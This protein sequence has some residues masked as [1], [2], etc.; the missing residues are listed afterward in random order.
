SLMVVDEDS[1]Q[2]RLNAASSAHLLEGRDDGPV[3]LDQTIE[4]G[5]HCG[6]GLRRLSRRNCLWQFLRCINSEVFLISIDDVVEGGI[7]AYRAKALLN[8][9]DDRAGE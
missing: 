9:G 5:Q 8:V 3:V 6:P 1:E 7:G 2:L 4:F